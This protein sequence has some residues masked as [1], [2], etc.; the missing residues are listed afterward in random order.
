[1]PQRRFALFGPSDK[2]YVVQGGFCISTFAIVK[3]DSLVL[4]LKPK[5]H[6]KWFEEW[7][8]NWRLYDSELLLNEYSRWRFP[9]SYVG[10]GEWVGNQR[11]R[12]IRTINV[13]QGVSRNRLDN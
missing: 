5:E 6:P 7:A 8:P 10:E 12:R 11:N 4:L 2:H 13:A 1:M 3:K 9:S